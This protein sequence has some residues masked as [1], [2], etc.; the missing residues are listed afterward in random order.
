M[1]LIIKQVMITASIA[2][3]SKDIKKYNTLSYLGTAS[4]PGKPVTAVSRM[5]NPP[6]PPSAGGLR[7]F[8]GRQTGKAGGSRVSI[9]QSVY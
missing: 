5:L 3:I 8:N 2:W 1:L 4:R 6:V 7:F 9:R